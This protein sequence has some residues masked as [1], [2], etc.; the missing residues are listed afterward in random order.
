[1][2][3]S[4]LKLA[5][6]IQTIMQSQGKQLLTMPWADFYAAADI[7]RFRDKRGDEIADSC[8]ALGIVV[9]YGNNV[10]TFCHDAHFAG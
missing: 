1:M 7:S 5:S 4:P 10:V 3:K 2:P 9:G 6:E 8:K